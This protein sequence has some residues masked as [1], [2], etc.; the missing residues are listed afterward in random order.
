MNR[1]FFAAAAAIL[2]FCAR[3]QLLKADGLKAAAEWCHQKAK[4]G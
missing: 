3:W 1:V 2:T 4:G